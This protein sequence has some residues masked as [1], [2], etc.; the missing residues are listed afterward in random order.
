MWLSVWRRFGGEAA[1]EMKGD[2]EGIIGF[3]EELWRK[4]KEK[5]R[6]IG[7]T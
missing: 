7:K 6:K 2:Y 4:M 3:E 5:L 1:S